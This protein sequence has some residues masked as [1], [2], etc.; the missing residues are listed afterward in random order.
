MREGT[1]YHCPVCTVG[2]DT[3][4]EAIACRNRHGAFE[5]KY[6]CCEICGRRFNIDITGW[7]KKM[8]VENALKCEKSHKND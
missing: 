6:V 8:G 7:G 1:V 5:K 3:E 2:Y 4:A